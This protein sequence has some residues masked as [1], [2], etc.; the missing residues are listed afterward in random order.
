MIRW[1]DH[2]GVAQIFFFLHTCFTTPVLMCTYHVG[3][4][5]KTGER[6]SSHTAKIYPRQKQKSKSI[7]STLCP[8]WTPHVAGDF[9]AFTAANLPADSKFNLAPALMMWQFTISS[10]VFIYK[11]WQIFEAHKVDIRS[12]HYSVR[13]SHPRHRYSR[14]S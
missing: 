11:R 7:D 9:F 10:L 14:Q 1:A 13:S 4:T 3:G 12:S 6:S 2:G 5:A 8:D